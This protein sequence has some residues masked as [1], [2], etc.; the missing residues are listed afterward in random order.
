MAAWIAISEMMMDKLYELMT[1]DI[2]EISLNVEKKTDN[3]AV[4][5][6]IVS[7]ETSTKHVKVR[8]KN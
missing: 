1:L 4:I 6:N 8:L 3:R 5:D 7:F 2:A